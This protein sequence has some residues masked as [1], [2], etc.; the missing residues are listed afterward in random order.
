MD[1]LDG[2]IWT[3]FLSDAGEVIGSQNSL[4]MSYYDQT[5]LLTPF[6]I[7]KN[8]FTHANY[9]SITIKNK[10]IHLKISR[11]SYPFLLRVWQISNNIAF[12]IN[13]SSEMTI[14]YPKKN[15]YIYGTPQKIDKINDID[16]NFWH[17]T[18]PPFFAHEIIGEYPI[19]TITYLNNK[20]TG[21]IVQVKNAKSIIVNAFT[22]KQIISGLDFNYSGLYYGINQTHNKRYFYVSSDWDMYVNSLKKN[23]IILS[24][25]KTPI[26]MYMP[27][28]KLS[29]E[30][31]IDTWI[32]LM[33]ME[34]DNNELEFE[35]MRNDSYM[36]IN[37]QRKPLYELM[38]VPYYS[39]D[40]NN[41]S[42]GSLHTNQ[43]IE[44]YKLF[45]EELK[46]NP[47][48]LFM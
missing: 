4:I 31:F 43:H 16:I 7:D 26:S 17:V 20:P 12:G 13:S 39:D 11:Y 27:Y 3:D 9:I 24:I 44:R 10:L 47:Q 37:I 45:G 6:D 2:L 14:N 35:I 33:F 48:K 34:K 42:L 19:G 29:R 23:D 40:V 8:H 25:N 5:V 18:L 15:H 22:L 41:I 28:D 32:T 21:I 38:Q 36:K 30:L 46:K 1:N